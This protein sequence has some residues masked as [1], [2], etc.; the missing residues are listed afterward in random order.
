[1]RSSVILEEF[2]EESRV[3]IFL[4]AYT[5]TGAG[6]FEGANILQRKSGDDELAEQFDLPVEE[7]QRILKEGRDLLFNARKQRVRPGTDDKALTAWNALMLN[8]FAEAARYLG[9][10]DYLE[11][12]I[13]NAEFILSSLHSGERLKR[14]WRKG[15]AQHNAYLEDYASLILGLLSL[16]Q[17]GGETRWFVHAQ[18]LAAELLAHFRDPAGGFFDTRDDHE[19]LV[20]RPKDLQDNAT[21]SGNAL[22]AKALL[23]LSAFTANQEYRDI[24]ESMLA[25]GPR[26]PLLL[27]N[28]LWL[29]AMRTRLR[30]FTKPPGCHPWRPKSASLESAH[31]RTLGDIPP[32]SRR[33]PVI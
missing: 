23:E 16:Y 14:S 4:S 31:R 20:T 17:S 3:E 13:R 5:I 8:A 1:M 10:N 11:V 30:N 28:R 32:S 12:A 27:S 6:N 9:R 19:R 24:A 15:R 26:S 22:A 25:E 7:V 33:C 2:D 21:P 29:L 18:N